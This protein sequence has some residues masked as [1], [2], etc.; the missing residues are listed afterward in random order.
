MRRSLTALILLL[1][2]ATAASAQAPPTFES[3]TVSTAAV[4]ISDATLKLNGRQA[5]QCLIAVEDDSVRFRLDGTAPTASVGQPMAAGVS[6]AMRNNADLRRLRFIQHESASGAATVVVTCSIDD[7]FVGESFSNGG[8]SSGMGGA[9]FNGV[10][11]DA[12]SGDSLTDT[13]NNALRVNIVAG[14]GSGGTAAVDNSA[15]TFG[16]TSIT[17]SGFVFDDVTPNAATENR[18]AAPRMSANRVPY[19]IIRDAAGNERGLNIDASGRIQVTAT[20]L[21]IQSGGVDLLSLAGFNAAFGV[22]GTPDAQFM[23]I[24]GGTGMTP[25]DVQGPGGSGLMLDST[26]ATISGTLLNI[27]NRQGIDAHLSNPFPTDGPPMYCNGSTAAPTGVDADGDS[28]GLYCDRLG[29]AQINIS[30]INGVAPSMGNGASGTGV[31]RVTI[32]NDSTGI[33]ALT[34]SSAQIGHLEAN[35]SINLVQLGGSSISATNPVPVVFPG[36]LVSGAIST[37]M[38]GTTSTSLV[39][40]T[41]SNY[42]YITSCVVSNASLTVSTDILLQD[43]S[44]G[45]TLWVLPAP[46]ATVATTGGGG[47]THT[48]GAAPLKVPTS[49]NSLFAA[50]VTT[51]SSTKVSCN[52][53]RSTVSY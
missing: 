7:R 38:T 36:T 14:A 21:D 4:G 23:S 13:A 51:G 47:A 28:V 45:T 34:T 10:L 37:A 49:G 24:Q 50:N 42:L 39:G 33:I 53:F 17:P 31:Q 44:G 6:F 18:I 41:A 11:L 5:N 35:Q 19:A 3:I 32:A 16:T 40:G 46:A 25:V 29:R 43:G 8:A 48:F 20:D 1:L 22:A 15:F 12:P 52:G 26:G 30:Q 9:T 27:Y 2:A